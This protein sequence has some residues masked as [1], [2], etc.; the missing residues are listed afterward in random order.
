LNNAAKYTPESGSIS[1]H[2][3]QDGGDVVVSVRDT[4]AGIPAEMQ[5]RIFEMFA[6]IDRPIER[7][8]PG[9]GIGLTIVK[10]LVQMHGGTIVVHSEGE[11]QGTEFTIRLPLHSER[12][13]PQAKS[14]SVES[15]SES[16]S[17]RRVLIVDD[18]KAAADLLSMVVKS[19]GNEVRTANNGEEALT[20]ASEF[21]PD[22]IFMDLGMP[23][24]NGY[25]AASQIR[26]TTWGGEIVLVALTGWGQEE[27]R[28]RTKEAG[29]DFHL[30]KPAEPIAIQEVLKQVKQRREH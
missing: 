13:T 23:H 20:V 26:T 12:Q 3:F 9:L 1:L 15:K 14:R 2:G 27:D 4:G 28:R 16:A 29:F 30:V 5:D 10:S 17:M 21:C 6:Q 18:N 7:T 19:L 24:M 11:N 8:H 22:V 25:E